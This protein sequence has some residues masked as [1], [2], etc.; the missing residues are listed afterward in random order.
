MQ[1]LASY[2]EPALSPLMQKTPPYSTLFAFACLKSMSFGVISNNL[3][4]RL[5]IINQKDFQYQLIN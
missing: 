3:Y 4:H 1:G 2:C 5:T